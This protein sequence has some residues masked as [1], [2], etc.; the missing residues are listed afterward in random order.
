[1][2]ATRMRRMGSGMGVVMEGGRPGRRGF[3]DGAYSILY[4]L[5]ILSKIQEPMDPSI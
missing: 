3:G 2:G 4:I 1:M 5:L